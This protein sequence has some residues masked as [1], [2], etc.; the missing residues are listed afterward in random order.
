MYIF[1]SNVKKRA[2]R[3][4]ERLFSRYISR[5]LNLLL[6]LEYLAREYSR[7]HVA[8]RNSAFHLI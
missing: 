3:F 2:R 7:G 4:K 5:T 8:L 6:E 1:D